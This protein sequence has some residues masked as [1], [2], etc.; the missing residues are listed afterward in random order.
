MNGYLFI[1]AIIREKKWIPKCFFLLRSSAIEF[2]SD[3]MFI[4]IPLLIWLLHQMFGNNLVEESR[5]ILN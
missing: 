1:K 3:L 4:Q 2:P 5:W